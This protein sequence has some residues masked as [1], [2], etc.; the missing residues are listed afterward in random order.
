MR[1]FLPA[2]AIARLAGG[3]MQPAAARVCWYCRPAARSVA[4]PARRVQ[5]SEQYRSPRS[6]WRQRKKTRRQSV[7]AQMTEQNESRRPRAQAGGLDSHA[8]I[9]DHGGA[10]SRPSW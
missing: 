1:H 7:R 8:R 5:V 4:W 10:E 2:G 9:C 3:V 6:Q